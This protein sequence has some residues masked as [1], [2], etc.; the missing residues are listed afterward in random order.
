MTEAYCRPVSAP[1]PRSERE[2]EPDRFGPLLDSLAD[3]TVAVR[4][5]RHVLEA[6]ETGDDSGVNAAIARLGVV[7][8]DLI[9]VA[10]RIAS[11]HQQLQHA[12]LM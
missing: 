6:L 8:R 10:T 5:R 11:V 9:A 2:V 12:H 1:T 4:E 7:E 3:L